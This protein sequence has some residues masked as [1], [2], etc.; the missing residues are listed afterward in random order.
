MLEQWFLSDGASPSV[1]AC[2]QA[3]SEADLRTGLVPKTI[4]VYGNLN[5]TDPSNP[6]T[7]MISEVD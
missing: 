5:T 7:M 4:H 3:N 1:F 6:S 2:F